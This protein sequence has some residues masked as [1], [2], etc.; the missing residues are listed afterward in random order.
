[1]LTYCPCF[2]RHWQHS[3]SLPPYVHAAT[4]RDR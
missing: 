1:M 2:F 3:D 4:F